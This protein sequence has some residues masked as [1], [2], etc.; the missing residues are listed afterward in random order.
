MSVRFNKETVMKVL[1]WAYERAVEGAPGLGLDSAE[2]LANEFRKHGG[3][4]LDQANSLIRW[5]VAK[6]AA[7]GFLSG[8]PGLPLMPITVPANISSVMWVQVRMVAAI[9][10][11]SGHD[12]RSDKVHTFVFICLC[13]N[14]VKDLM[15]EAGIKIGARLTEKMIEKMSIEAFMNINRAVGFRLVT[16]FGEKGIV[17]L[18]KTIPVVGGIVGGTFDGIGAATVGKAA[19]HVF[20]S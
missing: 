20:L 7:S 12:I 8:L 13:G 10:H 3:S 17:N 15:K 6:C 14:G 5:Q 19:R 18:G 9:A 16:K 4:T 11:L 1:D 2:E